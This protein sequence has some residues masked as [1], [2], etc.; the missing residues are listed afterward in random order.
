[1]VVIKGWS[2]QRLGTLAIM[3]MLK[4]QISF[5]TKLLTTTYLDMVG[6]LCLQHEQ[7]RDVVEIQHRAAHE[8]L[9]FLTKVLPRLGKAIDR[10]LSDGSTLQ[11]TNFKLKR[12]TK[13]PLFMGTL[14]S[15]LFE[16]DGRPKLATLPVTP[17]NELSSE[18]EVPGIVI[19]GVR[20]HANDSRETSVNALRV[21]RQVCYMFYKLVT[22]FTDAQVSRVCEDFITTERDLEDLDIYQHP[23][24]HAL[25]GTARSLIKRVLANASPYAGLPRHG[26]GAVS[27][28]ENP[29]EKHVFK[30][31]Y[32]RL[33][34]RFPYDHWFFTNSTHLCDELASL[35]AMEE[36]EYG[37]AKVVLVPKD[38]RGP[39]L[40]SCEPLEYQWIQQSLMS[41]LVTT[42]EN[43]PMTRG[44]VNFT[45]QSINQ[46]MALLGS[47]PP[48]DWCTL[49]M[50]EASDRVSL[51]LVKALFPEEWFHALYACRT[52]QTRMPD[53]SLVQMKKFAPMG[54][55]VCFPVEALVFFALSVSSL[56]HYTDTPLR[57]AV[58]QVY[59]YGDDIICH[60]ANHGVIGSTLELFG[61]KLNR[62]KC[63]VAGP[64]KESCGMDA[65]YGASVTPVRVRT[66]WSH[67]RKSSALSSYVALH[68]A[69]Y[70]RGW[71]NSAEYILEQIQLIWKWTIPVVSD[72][73][74][75]CI[76]FVREDTPRFNERGR[77][78]IRYNR[79]LQRREIQGLSNQAHTIMSESVGWS[80]LLRV[81]VD[82]ERRSGSE[83]PL[84][85]SQPT[86][87]YPIAHRAK[88]RRAWTALN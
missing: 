13:L 59:V 53:G 44:F 42:L 3:L 68:N 33:A 69:M 71:Y 48:F 58:S 9:S 36:L 7:Q 2:Q 81:I 4:S 10:S 41:V 40:I 54:S 66:T 5:Y 88:L 51:E 67:V 60:T 21:M 63:C 37:T 34:E 65:F 70:D 64:F 19:Q 55:A 1:M 29:G 28:G 52:P 86:G 6:V 76:A 78:K 80:L 14:F 46:K 15:V 8:G 39:R 43:H 32:Q 25:L 24:S 47:V 20:N 45:D 85:R 49:D 12:G 56:I 38:S 61:L 84:P 74:I 18:K 17:I 79:I 31:Y 72:R 27:T 26:P 35:D 77:W 82:M 22:P 23:S 62:D 73:N 50:K 83:R 30:R 87:T 16:P 11:V 57:K 75:G